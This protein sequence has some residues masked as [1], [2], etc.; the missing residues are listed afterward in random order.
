MLDRPDVTLHWRDICRSCG[1][2]CGKSCK[3]PEYEA[4]RYVGS[5][6]IYE[7][8][9]GTYLVDPNEPSNRIGALMVLHKLASGPGTYDLATVLCLSEGVRRRPGYLRVHAIR[10]RGLPNA[11][12]YSAMDPYVK[13]EMTTPHQPNMET[14]QDNKEEGKTKPALEAGMHPTWNVVE[15]KSVMDL[16]Y[17]APLPLNEKEKKDAE[18]AAWLLGNE[19]G[20]C[21]K[22]TLHVEVV[23]FDFVGDHDEVCCCFRCSTCCC[24][25]FC[26]DVVAVV[27][28]VVVLGS[29]FFFFSISV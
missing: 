12:D 8:L 18:H 2:R 14:G 11:D 15:H 10:G 16:R 20:L 24:R 27:V 3:R 23:D 13:I 17:D 1:A 22:C 5:D 4:S 29:F 19:D 7:A 21:D 6:E 9:I 28:V 25:S 26:C